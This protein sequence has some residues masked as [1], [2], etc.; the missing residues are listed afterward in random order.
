M[1]DAAIALLEMTPPS[2]QEDAAT[3]REL[4]RLRDDVH[5]Y[6]VAEGYDADEA[7]RVGAY[8]TDRVDRIT[9]F[10]NGERC[11]GHKSRYPSFRPQG[12]M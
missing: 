5:R 12:G 10:L 4:A 2:W 6:R 9:R 3:R 11:S 8:V 7:R 1:I